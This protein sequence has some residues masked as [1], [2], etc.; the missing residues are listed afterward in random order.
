MVQGGAHWKTG[1]SVPALDSNFDNAILAGA[2]LWHDVNTKCLTASSDFVSARECTWLLASESQKISVSKAWD[3]VG[4]K[5]TLS[6]SSGIKVSGLS[7]PFPNEVLFF[8]LNETV[9]T[10]ERVTCTLEGSSG[11]LHLKVRFGM[12]PDM[13]PNFAASDCFSYHHQQSKEECTTGP[14][15]KNTSVYVAVEALDEYASNVNLVC[16]ISG[17]VTTPKPTPKPTQPKPVPKCRAKKRKCR[18][19]KQC[20]N[21]LACDGPSSSKRI[22]KAC[23]NR[24]KNCTRSSECCAGLKCLGICF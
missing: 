13:D 5:S 16:T 8:R 9:H 3:A 14:A 7:L 24:Y 2:K 20:C 10:G 22:C 1:I 15:K 4:I 11:F 12:L 17:I 19:K 6:L 21:T 18:N 23:K